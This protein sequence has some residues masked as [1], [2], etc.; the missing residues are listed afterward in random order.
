MI[1]L[2]PKALHLKEE[3]KE[4]T[5]QVLQRRKQKGETR[6]LQLISF[7]PVMTENCSLLNQHRTV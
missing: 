3:V 2:T 4:V 5:D 6:N 7:V 1:P